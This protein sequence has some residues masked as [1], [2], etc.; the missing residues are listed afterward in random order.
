MR[1]NNDS[2]RRFL[3]RGPVLGMAVIACGM[4]VLSA[5]AQATGPDVARV[6]E[7][8]E[9]VVNDPDPNNNGPQVTCSIS[10]LSIET[11]YAAFDINYQTQPD[12]SAGRLQLHVWDPNNPIVKKD[13]PVSGML[14]QAGET[15]TWTQTMTLVEGHLRFKVVNGQSATW[16]NFGG[17]SQ[18]ITVYTRLADLNGYDPGVS[19]RNSGVCFA[20]NLVTSLTLKAVRWYDASGAMIQEVT[21]PQ[22]AYPKN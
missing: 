20:S 8:W 11:A 15:I 1:N 4:W 9:L 5:E 16:G 6:E 10:P 3:F 21:T 19:L 7:D 14:S 12:Y 18:A 13:F 17:D 2:Q 22:K